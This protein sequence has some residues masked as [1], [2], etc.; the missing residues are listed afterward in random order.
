MKT[1]LSKIQT[2][3]G[4]SGPMPEASARAECERLLRET[5]GPVVLW[6]DGNHPDFH[7]HPDNEGIFYLCQIYR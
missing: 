5:T 1:P 6:K 2:R 7:P 3:D 4:F